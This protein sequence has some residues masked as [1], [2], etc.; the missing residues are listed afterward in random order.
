MK[1]ILVQRWIRWSAL[2]SVAALLHGAAVAQ[3][4]N[5]AELAPQ[6]QTVVSNPSPADELIGSLEGMSA[7]NVAAQPAGMSE[8]DSVVGEKPERRRLG[9]VVRFGQDVLVN[10]NESANDIVVIFGTATIRGT[11]RDTVAILGNIINEGETGDTVAV[12]GNVKLGTNASVHGDAVAV[13]GNLKMEP[14]SRV[15]GDAVSVGGGFEQAEGT[16]VGGDV[17]GFKGFGWVGDYVEHCILK[18]RPL[19]PGLPWLWG[20][21]GVLLVLYLLIALVLPRPVAACASEIAS[22]PATTFLVGLLTK[23]LLAPVVTLILAIT[24]IG[25]VLIPFLSAAMAFAGVLGKIGLL[26]FVGQQLGRQTGLSALEKPLLAFLVAWAI[27][28][29]LYM[30]PVVGFIAMSVTSIW[31]LGAAVMAMFGGSRREL[32]QPPPAPAALVPPVAPIGLTP[33][34]NSTAGMASLSVA[35]SASTGAGSPGVPPIMA[36]PQQST[37]LSEDLLALP[38]ASFWERMA[39]GFL[40][41]MLVAIVNGLIGGGPFG[42]LV[43]VAYFAGMWTWRGTTIGGIV[44]NLKVV[45]YDGQPM[46]FGVALIRSLMAAFSVIVLF[47]GF[48]WIAFTPDRQAWHDKI[49]GTVVV[50]QPKGMPLL[51]L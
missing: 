27:L 29:G 44:M 15:S 31:A 18:L 43:A 12:L 2:A 1:Q 23:F 14:G 28:T 46:N 20:V 51:C 50:R 5:E 9:D 42:L 4:Q 47:L 24:G 39:A 48:L 7:T 41:V 37:A 40:D 33:T 10:T 6:E 32:P 38:R 17:I 30:V 22:R 13:A 8:T 11:A 25:V 35:Q 26:Q 45:R 21:V 36:A 3:E 16:Q 19:A 34:P 49:A